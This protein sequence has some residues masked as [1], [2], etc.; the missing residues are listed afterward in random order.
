MLH[1]SIRHGGIVYYRFLV[2]LDSQTKLQLMIHHC[3]Q[4]SF[5]RKMS[6]MERN[7]PKNVPD[8]EQVSQKQRDRIVSCK[9]KTKLAIHKNKIMRN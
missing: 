5:R 8:S 1:L 6:P 2:I 3:C 4:D 9:K 7:A